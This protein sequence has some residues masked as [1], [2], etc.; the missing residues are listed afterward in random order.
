MAENPKEFDP[1]KYLAV[2]RKAMKDICK[3]RY[4]AFGCAGQ[5]ARIKVISM[6]RMAER[7]KK[8]ELNAII[9]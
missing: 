5:A 2:A 1:R 9:N 7:Y 4:E 3:A 6:E 8:G